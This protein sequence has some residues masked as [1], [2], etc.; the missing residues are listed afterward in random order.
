MANPWPDP[1]DRSPVRWW[2]VA[3]VAMTVAAGAG[4]MVISWLS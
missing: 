4:M 3:A 2:E 1:R